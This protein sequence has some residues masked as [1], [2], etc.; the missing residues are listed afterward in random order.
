MYVNASRLADAGGNW[1]NASNAGAFFL[2]VARSASRANTS[3]GA[4]LMFL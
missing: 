3:V 1:T 4:R 2:D